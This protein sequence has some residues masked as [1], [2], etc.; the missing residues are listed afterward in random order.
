MNLSPFD[1]QILSALH[2]DGGFLV[3]DIADKVPQQRGTVNNR[4]HCAQ[5]RFRLLQLEKLGLVHRLT[6]ETPI[7]WVKSKLAGL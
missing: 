6:D 1:N 4:Q 3:R 7:A 5:I 2:M